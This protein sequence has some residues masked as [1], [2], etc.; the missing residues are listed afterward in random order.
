[1]FKR[2]VNFFSPPQ[3]KNSQRI[4]FSSFLH[5][6]SLSLSSLAIS[7]AC[8]LPMPAAS[9]IIRLRLDVYRTHSK[10]LFGKKV[11]EGDYPPAPST[12]PEP[13]PPDPSLSTAARDPRSNDRRLMIQQGL[14]GVGGLRRLVKASTMPVG[15]SH[16]SLEDIT[17]NNLQKKPTSFPPFF[18][19]FPGVRTFF[20][21][22]LSNEFVCEKMHMTFVCSSCVRAWLR[23]CQV[24]VRKDPLSIQNQLSLFLCVLD[25]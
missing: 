20:I 4:H 14:D 24:E 15:G 21:H 8:V 5:F 1:M 2:G 3:Q 16:T 23:L 25:G 17:C 22:S 13:A 9:S 7:P 18:F 11:M 10:N 6:S 12:P 19:L